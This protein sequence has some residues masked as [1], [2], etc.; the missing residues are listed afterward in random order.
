[1]SLPSCTGSR[2]RFFRVVVM[3][4]VWGA[5]G[6]TATVDRPGINSG[7]FK[8][9]HYPSTVEL[10]PLFILLQV[11]VSASKA[12]ACRDILTGCSRELGFIPV[13]VDAPDTLRRHP[14]LARF[15][16]KPKIVAG[17]AW[18]GEQLVSLEAFGCQRLH[19]C[20]FRKP[21][22]PDEFLALLEE[23]RANATV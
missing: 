2:G 23:G 19:G 22:P 1:M 11:S 5:P 18:T 17:R 20:T 4:L 14:A 13:W 3:P 6:H 7:D 21:L 10:D 12:A 9:T 16:I 15:S 8:L